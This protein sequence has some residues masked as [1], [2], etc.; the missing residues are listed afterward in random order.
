MHTVVGGCDC[1]NISVHAE[2]TRAPD[3]YSPRACDCN[4]CGKHGASYLS[5]PLG[6]LR[7]TVR[8]KI[9]EYRQGSETARFLLCGACGV[10]AGV[11]HESEGR[12]YGALNARAMDAAV[13]FATEQ[14]VSPKRL[15]AAEKVERWRGVW[16]AD[17]SIHASPNHARANQDTR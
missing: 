16:F 10:L 17:V 1:G 12:L 3:S 2:L 8:Y 4:F 9:A 15:S 14:P 13:K 5:D 6:V 7:F 11:V